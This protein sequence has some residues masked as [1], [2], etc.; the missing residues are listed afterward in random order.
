MQAHKSR[1]WRFCKVAPG[2]VRQQWA[3]CFLTLVARTMSSRFCC[4]SQVEIYSSV[5][6][7]VSALQ[8]SQAFMHA[9]SGH[10]YKTF[11]MMEVL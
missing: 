6:P 5:L 8:S 2:T 4:F 3:C 1:C 7:C 9:L 10:R 11:S